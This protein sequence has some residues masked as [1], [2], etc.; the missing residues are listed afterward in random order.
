[1]FFT[2]LGF[3]RKE[4]KEENKSIFFLKTNP[5]QKSKMKYKVTFF[6]YVS[7]FPTHFF[8]NSTFLLH[9]KLCQWATANSFRERRPK[10]MRCWRNNYEL[11]YHIITTFHLSGATDVLLYVHVH[12][13][14]C[15][16]MQV[17]MYPENQ[18]TQKHHWNVRAQQEIQ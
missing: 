17:C 2:L 4:I 5:C 14:I 15:A 10:K 9:T 1:M 16:Y 18:E 8:P 12:I 3:Q 7:T 11:I 13:Y 6:Y